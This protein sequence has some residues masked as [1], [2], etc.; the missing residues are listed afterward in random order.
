MRFSCYVKQTRFRAS[1]CDSGVAYYAPAKPCR[2]AG[3]LRHM[4]GPMR[5]ADPPSAV[6]Q[7]ENPSPPSPETPSADTIRVQQEKILASSGFAHAER[8]SRFLRFTVESALTGHGDQI[9]EYLLGVEVFDREASYNPQIDPIVRVEAGRVRSKL[10]EYYE[11][12]GREDPIVIEFPKGTYV[13]VFRRRDATPREDPSAQ[14]SRDGEAGAAAKARGVRRTKLVAAGLVLAFAAGIGIAWWWHR[15]RR[16]NQ[17]PILTRL[18]SES[19]LTTDPAVSPDGR[20]LAYASDRGGAGNLDIWVQQ[21][22]G[23]EP[24]RITMDDADDREPSFSPD[25]SKIVFQSDRKGG[26]IYLV[27]ALGGEPRLLA[28]KG[29]SPRFSPNGEWIAYHFGGTFLVWSKLYVVPVVG[30]I[31]RPIQPDFF[32]ARYPVW[33]PDGKHL[34][35]LGK[36]RAG[37]KLEPSEFD[38]WVTPVD[39]GTAIKTQAFAGFRRHGLNATHTYDV[40]TPSAP[41]LGLNA[42]GHFVPSTWRA[43][44][45][46]IFFSAGLADSTNLWKVSL[47]KTFEVAGPPGRLTSGTGLEMQPSVAGDETLVFSSLVSNTDIWSLQVDANVGKVIGEIQRLTQSTATEVC[48]TISADGQKLAFLSDLSGQME[49]RTKA[50]DSGKETPLSPGPADKQWPVISRDGSRIAFTV[51]EKQNRPIYV[52]STGSAL[53]EKLCDHCGRP[54]DWSSDGKRL[55]YGDENPPPHNDRI[56]L[57]KIVSGENQKELLKDSRQSNSIRSPRF[58][59]ENDWIAFYLVTGP[60]KRQIFIAPFRNGA[61]PDE[62]EWIAVTNGST[63]DIEPRWSPD[64]SILYFLSGRDQYRCIWAQRLDRVTKRPVSSA[65]E[66]YPFHRARLSSRNPNSGFTG[67]SVIRDKIVL[68]LEE[69][70]GNIWM[71]KLE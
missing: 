41:D 31:S 9:K 49:V 35:F 67:F 11:T 63:F 32:D 4:S 25:G 36:G 1:N 23:G 54:E 51:Y 57:L 3:P 21:I 60:A 39:G 22:S 2:D 6:R 5:E 61:A 27:S 13:P 66:V 58:S 33:S 38:W 42:S 47:S 59:S 30:G 44:G 17:G 43:N 56:G 24:I 46:T 15:T 28:E 7:Y 26:G 34:L 71:T 29:R 68:S 53:M 16:L 70:T 14:I 8:R 12:E 20:L 65:F 48:P 55:F 40:R 19:G 52:A 50:L 64:S 62:K 69:V 45:N 37:H 18:T 10:K